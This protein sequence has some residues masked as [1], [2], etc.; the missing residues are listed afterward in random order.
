MDQNMENKIFEYTSIIHS[1]N[2]ITGSIA[3][4]SAG[5]KEKKKERIILF[6]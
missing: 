2:K 1:N 6:A 5:K 3:T 4:T